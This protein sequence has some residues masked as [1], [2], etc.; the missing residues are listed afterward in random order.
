M[1]IIVV[2]ELKFDYCIFSIKL[3][4]IKVLL[5]FSC[6]IVIDFLLHLSS[7][8]WSNTPPNF[9]S[10]LLVWDHNFLLIL[11]NKN[12]FVGITLLK[13]NKIYKLSSDLCH[14]IPN[15]LK[16]A[17]YILLKHISSN[18]NIPLSYYNYFECLKIIIILIS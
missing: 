6:L 5:N 9:K 10:I 13:I 4:L 15:N 18:L 16:I 8:I 11:R 14:F 7:G 1:H 12:L 17:K 2:L 3:L